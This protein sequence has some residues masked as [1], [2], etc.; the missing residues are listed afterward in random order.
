MRWD[1][2][3]NANGNRL[4]KLRAAPSLESVLGKIQQS[5][6]LCCHEDQIRGTRFKRV[7]YA[8]DA[9]E[10]LVDLF[11][12]S[13]NGYRASFYR[14]PFEGIQTNRV[15][16]DILESALVNA[17]C[18]PNAG[19]SKEFLRESLRSASAK[20]WLA[21]RGKETVQRCIGCAGEWGAHAA[22]HPEILNDRWEFAGHYKANWGRQAPR[23]TKLKVFG[24]FLDE[25]GNEFIPADKRFRAQEICAYGWS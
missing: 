13:W 24:A 14:G 5:P 4:E 3:L 19:L 8:I 20:I 21:E 2:S 16:L 25:N 22:Q 10:E 11:F 18:A 12:N 17:S 9:G 23:L 7:A 1:F 6:I 15:C